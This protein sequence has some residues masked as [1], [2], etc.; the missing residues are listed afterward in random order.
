MITASLLSAFINLLVGPSKVAHLPNSMSV[1]IVGQVLRGVIDPFLF[2]PVLPEM[3]ASVTPHY[4]KN[5]EGL[6]N[7][8]ASGL[9]CTFYGLGMI[10]GPIIGSAVTA[11]YS[12]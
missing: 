8:S 1:M 9:F 11:K 3:I 12:F 2:I 6:I 5:Q 10:I 7:D 4:N